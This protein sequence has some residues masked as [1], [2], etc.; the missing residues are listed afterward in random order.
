MQRLEKER[1]RALSEALINK[2]IRI[3]SQENENHVIE[4]LSS[5]IRKLNKL[6]ATA[7]QYP[8]DINFQFTPSNLSINSEINNLKQL[9]YSLK[10]QN[11]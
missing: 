11:E 5:H 8:N 3:Q 1:D 6:N 7:I 4:E 2:Q 9:A 10:Y